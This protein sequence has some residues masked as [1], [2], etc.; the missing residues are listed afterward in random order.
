MNNKI[1]GYYEC[2]FCNKNYKIKKSYEKHF[3][4]CSIINKSVTERKAE[5]EEYENIPSM[6]EMYNMIQILIL[7]NDKLEKQVEK[8]YTWIHKNKKKINVIDWL[9]ENYNLSEN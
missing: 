8:M 7:K 4:L 1:S 5:N 3:M 9:N 6:R 2:G